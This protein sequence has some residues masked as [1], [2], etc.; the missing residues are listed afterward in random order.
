[1][2][3][4][5]SNAL[6]FEIISYSA[7]YGNIGLNG[8][9]G[10]STEYNG[11]QTTNVI[12]EN[13]CV[14]IYPISLH[15]PANIIINCTQELYIKGYSSPTIQLCPTLTFKCDEHIVGII[16]KPGKKTLPYKLNPGIHHLEIN[17]T[18]HSW[19]HSVWLFYTKRKYY[20]A[21]NTQHLGP[22]GLLN[23]IFNLVNGLTLAHLNKRD[24]CN[25][26]FLPNY[27]SLDSV[28]LSKIVD[29]DH[30]NNLL[31][32]IN[33]DVMVRI[34]PILDKNNWIIPSYH[35]RFILV[36]ALEYISDILTQDDQ[37]YI[38]LGLVFGIYSSGGKFV[39]EG[40][41]TI[42]TDLKFNNEYYKVLDYCVSKFLSEKYNVI[43]LRIEDDW[44]KYYMNC[45]GAD[46]F[47]ECSN[48]LINKYFEVMHNTFDSNDVIYV[49]THLL[50]SE[51]KNNFIMT[52]IQRKYPHAVF[53]IPWREH[54]PNILKGR[55]IDAL[56][57]YLICK[58][59]EKFIGLGASTFSIMLHTILTRQGK[60]AILT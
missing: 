59:A 44:I 35:D 16:D 57:D 28:C 32:S 15:A 40:R 46:T 7:G 39:S 21:N 11:I 56:I 51:N 20:K 9:L 4:S 50:K 29:I 42:Y 13:K 54:F 48:K 33:F 60:T 27:N 37:E 3:F 26:T 45:I 23:Q 49:A 30:L 34:D 10:Y 6:P 31:Q 14:D 47:E 53:S 12:L 41:L 19:S 55:E 5:F 2:E 36:D 25:P 24:L 22:T 17:T 58:R 52:E 8:N 43:H 38:D 18:Y 1:M